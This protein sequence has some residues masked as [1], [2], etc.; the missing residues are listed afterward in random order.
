MVQTIDR[1][2]HPLMIHASVLLSLHRSRATTTRRPTTE[3]S[4]VQETSLAGDGR[5][6]GSS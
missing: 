6:G 5:T 1:L 2:I 4:R 3:T